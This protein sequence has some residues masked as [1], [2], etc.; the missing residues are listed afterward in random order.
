[1]TDKPERRKDR[2]DSGDTLGGVLG[3]EIHRKLS[4]ASEHPAD[5]GKETQ[6][7]PDR[8][9]LNE[10]MHLELSEASQQDERINQPVETT[11]TDGIE[12]NP[13]HSITQTEERRLQD[14]PDVKSRIQEK[15]TAPEQLA[16][17][18]ERQTI[19][20]T[21][22]VKTRELRVE[23]PNLNPPQSNNILHKS[24]NGLGCKE[25]TSEHPPEQE[26]T[27][28][29]TH[30]KPSETSR[31]HEVHQPGDMTRM[32]CANEVKACKFVGTRGEIGEAHKETAEAQRERD[33][34]EILC[35]QVIDEAVQDGNLKALA[36]VAEDLGDLRSYYEN[37]E[38]S[39][40][41]DGK[42]VEGKTTRVKLPPHLIEAI[43]A[44]EGPMQVQLINPATGDTYSFYKDF[45]KV[46]QPDIDI[47]KDIMANLHAHEDIIV[48]MKQQPTWEFL[49][50]I[51]GRAS[52][53][54]KFNKDGV[55]IANFGGKEIPIESF[56]YDHLHCG[57][58]GGATY[59]E[60]QIKDISNKVA[61][62]RL[63]DNGFG[64]PRF[65]IKMGDHFRPVEGLEYDPERGILEIEYDQSMDQNPKVSL[66]FKET[67][68]EIDLDAR[69]VPIEMIER[70]NKAL[71]MHNTLKLGKVGEEI[72]EK[73]AKEKLKATVFNKD[74]LSGPDRKIIYDN[75]LG[76]LEAKFTTYKN[77]L[78]TKLNEAKDQMRSRLIKN[79][80]YRHGVAFAVYFDKYTGHF[81]YVYYIPPKT[82]DTT[83]NGPRHVKRGQ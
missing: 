78:G 25:S 59:M 66:R 10:E 33:I 22:A 56:K 77:S 39:L 12:A 81:D 18:G 58:I 38:L 67:P 20:E 7:K 3:S 61:R 83:F 55:L 49:N 21:H 76:I 11:R 75:E 15:G 51:G 28:W 23:Q 5:Q 42:T 8:R 41:L 31:L 80:E 60:F 16:E 79:S 53:V 14:S 72:A 69:M 40:V 71:E 46:E 37:G 65:T 13:E 45:H 30:E 34:T 2:D 4:E 36:G 1:M 82:Q 43:I 44:E 74:R 29:E 19:P 54:I 35:K 17:D 68:N 26:T 70:V 48:K 6:E 52:E 73:F 32:E 57:E 27:A 63:Y 47:P 64:E 9:Y 50:Q 24:I 62:F